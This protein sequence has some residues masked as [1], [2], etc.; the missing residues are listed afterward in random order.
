MIT[1]FPKNK[2]NPYS[3]TMKKKEGH[4]FAVLKYYVLMKSWVTSPCCFHLSIEL[5]IGRRSIPTNLVGSSV[6][7]RF[8]MSQ[9][10]FDENARIKG[11]WRCE[12]LLKRQLQEFNKGLCMRFVIRYNNNCVLALLQYDT[13][14]FA[15]FYHMLTYCKLVWKEFQSISFHSGDVIGMFNWGSQPYYIA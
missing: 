1:W 4:T 12:F 5:E 8:K 6:A 14:I 7:I 11:V 10:V 9:V 15:R 2:N 3:M 13:S